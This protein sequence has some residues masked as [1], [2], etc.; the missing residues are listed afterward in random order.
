MLQ[1]GKNGNSHKKTSTQTNQQQKKPTHSSKK[2][3]NSSKEKQINPSLFDRCVAL[4]KNKKSVSSPKST[5]KKKSATTEEEKIYTQDII[6]IK[7]I[8]GGMVFMND[9]RV[10]GIQE[11]IPMNYYQKDI[12]EKNSIYYSYKGLFRIAP[13]FLHFKMRTEKADVEKLINSILKANAEEESQSVLMEM[14][15]Y[16]DHIKTLQQK[17]SICKRFY[18]IWN[19]EG[20]SNGKKSNDINQIYQTMEETRLSIQQVFAEIGQYT[21]TPDDV[22]WYVCELLY[23]FF[24]P[25]TSVTEPFSQ[26]FMRIRQD[27]ARFN[28]CLPKNKRIDALDEDFIAP[29]GI[30]RKGDYI[31]MDG[32]YHT[33][34]T[35]KDSGHPPKVVT[36]WTNSLCDGF[37]YDLDILSERLPYDATLNSIEQFNR[38]TRI[39]ANKNRY[40]PDK[41]KE[42]SKAIS[43]KDFITQTMRNQDEDLWNCI[44]IITIRANSYQ[45]M[46]RRKNLLVKRLKSLGLYTEDSFLTVWKNFQ[47]VMPFTNINRALFN[48]NKRNYLT[49]SMAALYNYTAFELFDDDGVVLGRNSNGAMVAQNNF[50]T[51]RYT[52]AN[53]LLLGGSGSGKT[54]TELLMSRRMRLT[55]RRT[56]FILPVKG[57]E[58]YDAIRAIDG[59]IIKMFPGGDDCINIMQIRPEVKINKDL[60]REGEKVDI[61]PLLSKKITT[62]TTW[63]QLLM[64]QE[65]LTITEISTLN[66]II[67]DVYKRFGITNDND[68]IY[69]SKKHNLLKEMPILQD[70]Y[71]AILRNEDM[72]KIAVVLIPFIEGACQNFNGQTNINLNN[73]CIAFDVDEDVVGEDFISAFMYIAYDFLYDLVKQD[74]MSRDVIILDEAW[75]MM[76]IDDCA[77]QVYK[78]SKLIRGYGGS[79]II[80]SQDI[81]EFLNQSC[82]YGK[83]IITNTEIK[84]LMKMK[85]SAI[86]AL[87]DV[88]DL[89]TQDKE[90]I[91]KY[92]RGTGIIITDNDKIP[93][94]FLSSDREEELFTTDINVKERIAK[95]KQAEALEQQKNKKKPKNPK[96]AVKTTSK[97]TKSADKS[98]VRVSKA[99]GSG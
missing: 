5:P 87:C 31:I 97:K 51:Q 21:F 34:I 65:R 9:G 62:I 64:K 43:N 80:A 49:S 37:G 8:Y 47:M 3:T 99:R 1:N 94:T 85:K 19:Y 63:I 74:M 12:S 14:S 54:F 50:N 35:L 83:A 66:G 44:I 45:N 25:K 68:S 39:S 52:N 38:F 18:I 59:T 71:D 61:S 67:T 10:V 40:N 48:K 81:E 93:I 11:V 46:V 91:K 23:K 22:S 77:K 75:K 6:G 15:D 29:K 53:M 70:L 60:L 56:F 33:F 88:I 92:P 57:Y 82:G 30:A 24:N 7:Q 55:G 4:A 26:R 13:R 41:Q 90:S 42:L 76:D 36:G 16:I 78:M 20:D 95:K 2:S 72:A 28:E 96:T 17:D 84:I 86:N 98:T 73:K 79:I 58:Y 89:N 32:I 69:R 27:E